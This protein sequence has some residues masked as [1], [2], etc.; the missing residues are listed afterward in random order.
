MYLS[1][2]GN[3]MI[4]ALSMQC[5]VLNHKKAIPKAKTTNGFA[6]IFQH[7]ACG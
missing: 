6:Y 1:S 4:D 2:L 3:F 5:L 7:S